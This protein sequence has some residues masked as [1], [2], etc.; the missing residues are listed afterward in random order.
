MPGFPLARG[1]AWAGARVH[2]PSRVT[3][4]VGHHQLSRGRSNLLAHTIC[5]HGDGG[6]GW[7]VEPHGGDAVGTL[8]QI[9]DAKRRDPRYPDH[10]PWRLNDHR[11][12]EYV[13]PAS[14]LGCGPRM[15]ASAWMVGSH[16]RWKR[17]SL[18]TAHMISRVDL[19]DSH[20]TWKRP[21]A[22]NSPDL[23]DAIP[24][25]YRTVLAEA[26]ACGVQGLLPA[27][28]CVAPARARRLLPLTRGWA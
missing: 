8:L 24:V 19:V 3:P 4:A 11:L 14:L 20:G 6:T 7:Q 22:S 15:W 12:R 28:R 1:S 16:G 13:G 2:T 5:L 9:L 18:Q 26:V 10:T 17:P 21:C 27:A 23:G 25:E